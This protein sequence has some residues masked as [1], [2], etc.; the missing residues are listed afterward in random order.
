MCLKPA[1]DASKAKLASAHKHA[2]TL[3][4]HTPTHGQ[5]RKHIA[6]L[7]LLEALCR[8]SA[9]ASFAEPGDLQ[10]Q[11]LENRTPS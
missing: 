6:L 10:E 4:A 3:A 2:H 8:M 7:S 1:T 11:G 9:A 5:R